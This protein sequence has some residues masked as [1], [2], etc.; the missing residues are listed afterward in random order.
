[1]SIKTSEKT[2]T[3]CGVTKN[4]SEFHNNKNTKD[5]RTSFCAVCNNEKIKAY[6][7]KK[8]AEL[9]DKEWRR[10]KSRDVRKFRAKLK[11]ETGSTYPPYQRAYTNAT[12]RL[13]ELHPDDFRALLR[14]ERHALGLDPDTQGHSD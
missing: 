4:L 6:Q 13:R 9:G 2:C 3:K 8:R 14:E 5:G 10:L 1:M 12:N 11:T 7:T